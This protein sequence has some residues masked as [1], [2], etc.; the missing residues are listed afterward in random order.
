MLSP[1]HKEDISTALFD[2]GWERRLLESDGCYFTGETYELLKEKKRIILSFVS[3]VGTGFTGN[4]NIE[5]VIGTSGEGK[6]FRLWLSR[7]RNNKW[8]RDL[9]EWADQLEEN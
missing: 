8:K 5:E 3:D 7:T 4:K 2:K 1:W 6:E 9:L